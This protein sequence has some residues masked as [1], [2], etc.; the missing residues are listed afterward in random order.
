MPFIYNHAKLMAI[1][2]REQG[3]LLIPRE[4]TEMQTLNRPA[5]Y[6]LSV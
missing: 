2:N 4:T 1:K 5:E 3:K 6:L